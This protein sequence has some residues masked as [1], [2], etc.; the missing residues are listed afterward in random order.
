M[1]YHIS[2]AYVHREENFA[3]I[4]CGGVGYKLTVSAN[5]Q[6]ALG[7]PEEGKRVKLYTY[8]AVREDA[9][10]L[11][12][13]YT[14]AELDTF[15]LLIGVSGVGPKAAMA[16]LSIMTPEK[17]ALAVASEDAKA[18]A[19]ANGVG[20]KTAARVVL[21]LRDKFNGLSFSGA[22]GLAAP[23]SPAAPAMKGGA[24]AEASEA[25]SMLGYKQSEILDA[26]R[27]IDTT[28]KSVEDI[29]TAALKFF[30]K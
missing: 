9:M 5:T 13:F 16:I 7:M 12:G 10:E 14:E 30:S 15:R 25:L 28:G 4:D 27:R 21:E 17:L 3:V 26:L 22:E 1:F 8:L 24:M 19:R 29:I 23:V 2:G 6:T 11:F 20:G 18:I